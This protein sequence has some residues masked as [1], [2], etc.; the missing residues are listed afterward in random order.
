MCIPIIIKDESVTNTGQILCYSNC[1][2]INSDSDI[3]DPNHA[4][5]LSANDINACCNTDLRTSGYS[6]A[7]SPVCTAACKFCYNYYISLH[8]LAI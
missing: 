6:S 5:G 3:T 7:A 4:D 8:V 2:L 1:G